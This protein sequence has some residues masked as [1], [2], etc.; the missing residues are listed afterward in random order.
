MG[1]S[2][3]YSK[4]QVEAVPEQV[5]V[6]YRARID[7]EALVYRPILRRAARRSGSCADKIRCCA[8]SMS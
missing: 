2:V 4:S 8:C 5:A 6:E 3:V 1:M 7:V